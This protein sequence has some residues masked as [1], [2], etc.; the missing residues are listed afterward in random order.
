VEWLQSSLII[1]FVAALSA[2]GVGG[3]LISLHRNW[4]HD[5]LSMMISAGGGLL[6][7]ITLLD[8]LPHSVGEEGGAFIPLI[9][10]GYSFLF[11]LELPQGK[12]KREGTAGMI[13]VYLGLFIHAFMEGMSLLASYRVDPQLGISLLLALIVHKIPDGITIASIILATTR[14]RWLALLGSGSLGLATLLGVMAMVLAD[15]WLSLR[16]SQAVL[17]LTSGVF[18]YVSASHLVPFVRS[19]GRIQAGLCFFAAVLFYMFVS[20]YVKVG[21][22]PHA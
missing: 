20:L 1:L 19:S 9:L 13:G 14:S 10:V 16:W 22:H 15:Y 17:A 6:L 12:E 5:A 7:A 18:L 3:L 4:S 8:L 21:I 2:S 11:I